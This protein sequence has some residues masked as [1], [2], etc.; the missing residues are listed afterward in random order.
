MTLNIITSN[1]AET[2]ALGKKLG[3][4]LK[5]GDCV[6]LAGE[7]GA[8]KTTFTQGLA[9]ALKIKGDVTSPTF[10]IAR[11]HKSLTDGPNLVHVDAYR[12]STLAEISQLDLVTDIET[13]ILVV[14]WGKGL[15]NDLVAEPIQI[16]INHNDDDENKREFT[17]NATEAIIKGLS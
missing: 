16:I 14:E 12:L 9:S 17:I 7:L 5:A 2:K 11:E 13:A 4:L 1:A 15:V 8:G 10:V 3:A 6:L